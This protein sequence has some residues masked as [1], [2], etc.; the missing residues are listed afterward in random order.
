[1]AKSH[2]S[3]PKWA[4]PSHNDGQSKGDFNDGHKDGLMAETRL[5]EHHG[6]TVKR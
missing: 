4:N 2:S 5:N 6:L 1:M 3:A